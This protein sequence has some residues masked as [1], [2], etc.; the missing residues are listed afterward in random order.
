MGSCAIV[1]NFVPAKAS[2]FNKF[3]HTSVGTPEDLQHQSL[4]IGE[5]PYA[6]QA[7]HQARAKE[8]GGSNPLTA[9]AASVQIAVLPQ[10]G[11]A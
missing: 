3:R 5:N 4:E 1:D 11:D 8:A 10:I 6:N 2:N 9:L 7:G